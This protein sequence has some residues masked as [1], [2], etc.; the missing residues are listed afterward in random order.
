MIYDYIYKRLTKPKLQ[1]FLH[2][3]RTLDHPLEFIEVT[4][5]TPVLIDK[6]VFIIHKEWNFGHFA[7]KGY[8]LSCPMT[9]G[10]IQRGPASPT[11]EEELK[12]LAFTF[13]HAGWRF[14]DVCLECRRKAT[15]LSPNA[16]DWIAYEKRINLQESME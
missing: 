6:I 7:A 11:I 8:R 15:L 1:A 10:S 4:D 5:Y 3:Q 9:G 12:Q 14:K 2:L 16:E 13:N